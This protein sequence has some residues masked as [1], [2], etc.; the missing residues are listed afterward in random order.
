MVKKKSPETKK[1]LGRPTKYNEDIQKKA[2]QFVSSLEATDELPHIYDLA[3]HLEVDSD[4]IGNWGEV[5]PKFF[6]TIKKLKKLQE[7][8]L[9]NKGLD[10]T[11][12]PP[13]AMFLLKCNH[14]FVDKVVN[15]NIETPE[16]KVE[17]L[18]NKLGE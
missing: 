14:G 10:N 6:G 12:N 13:M 9:M 5:H 16:S 8:R 15:V 4:T 11:W 1:K 18:L 17:N 7:R 2:D 3:E